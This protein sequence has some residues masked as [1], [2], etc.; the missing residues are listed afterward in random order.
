MASG[1]EVSFNEGSPLI[2]RPDD[3][4]DD[5]EAS[6]DVNSTIASQNS[7]NLPLN[8][9]LSESS[10]RSQEQNSIVNPIKKEEIMTQWT[11]SEAECIE[12]SDSEQNPDLIPVKDEGPMTWKFSGGEC[13]DLLDFEQDPAALSIRTE[14][15]DTPWRFTRLEPVELS[16]TEDGVPGQNQ[17]P[18]ISSIHEDMNHESTN[19]EDVIYVG[20]N[21]G[22]LQN[23]IANNK[24]ENDQDG[25]ES[26][27]SKMQHH[28]KM[29]AERA[30]GRPLAEG[31]DQLFDKLQTS[32]LQISDTNAL[33]SNN[34]MA[35]TI[36]PDLDPCAVYAFDDSFNFS[37]S[38]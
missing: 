10:E 29:L 24:N 2:I 12:L 17:L 5:L 31:A 38:N 8:G 21:G 32:Q 27:R 35:A 37:T 11:F 9:G 25:E 6:F 30:L 20:M 28:Q 19:N 13:I 34:W 3:S 26:A 18:A 15:S 33:D 16:A 4:E 1:S 22:D 14:N 7:S 36:D 23:K